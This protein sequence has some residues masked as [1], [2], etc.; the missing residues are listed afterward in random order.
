[1]IEIKT[2]EE[3][4][5]MRATCRLATATLAYLGEQVRSGITTE[6]LDRLAF[7]YIQDHGATP[8]PLN[9]RGFPKSI[10]TSPNEVI[11][12]GIPSED[13]VLKDGDI[14]NIDVTTNLNGFH[15]DTNRTFFVGD[16]DP[17]ARQLVEVTHQCMMLGI[18]QVKPG[19]KIRDIG[20]AIQR[21]ARAHRYSVVRQFCGHGI[22]REFH[23]PPQVP[24]FPMPGQS[25]EMEPGMTFTVEPMINECRWEAKVLEDGWTAVTIDGHLSAQFEH[26]VLV[27]ENGYEVLTRWESDAD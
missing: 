25:P 27:T 16:V 21:K 19:N 2:A 1:M 18:A 14:L 5:H 26:T 12:H 11:C 13:V 15:G 9:Y 6:S 8:S 3:I 4:E 23:A 10:C 20:T 22:G 7:E 17:R 24:H